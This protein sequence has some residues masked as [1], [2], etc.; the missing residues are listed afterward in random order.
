MR[1][2]LVRFYSALAG[3]RIVSNKS[4]GEMRTYQALT[5][6]YN[7]PP[8]T[9][10][11]LGLL[12]QSMKFKLIST[13]TSSAACKKYNSLCSCLFNICRTHINTWGHPGLDWASGMPFL[14]VI[15][16]LNMTFAM[17]F[18][19]YGGFNSSLTYTENK[20]TYSEFNKTI[21]DKTSLDIIEGSI[22]DFKKEMIGESF[23]IT[24]PKATSSCGCGLSFSV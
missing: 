9:P 11:G 19:S 22:I 12:K 5:A 15:S 20:E 4:L 24:N 8:G 1:D 14:G 17:G 7:P 3:G 23:V 16:D 2:R 13:S 21:I 18:D 10:Y 6:G